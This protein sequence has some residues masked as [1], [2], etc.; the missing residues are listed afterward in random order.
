MV[1]AEGNQLRW[2]ILDKD[3]RGR[4]NLLTAAF[5]FDRRDM[6][7]DG[8]ASTMSTTLFL[9][10]GVVSIAVGMVSIAHSRKARTR[11][12]RVRSARI[13]VG[14]FGSLAIL[15]AVNLLA[16]VLPLLVVAGLVWLLV[17]H[18]WRG[19]SSIL[20]FVEQKILNA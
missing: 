2:P 4:A 7:S 20:R 14:A 15:L 9:T 11:R 17:R 3:G 10:L 1:P 19:N 8:M 18:L 5:V 16:D 13:A 12:L 6:F